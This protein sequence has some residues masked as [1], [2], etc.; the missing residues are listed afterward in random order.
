M[1]AHHHIPRRAIQRPQNLEYAT[2]DWVDWYNNG[3]RHSTLGNAPPLEYERDDYATLNRE[4]QP[5]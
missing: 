2:A 3:R 4:A 5:A 1:H